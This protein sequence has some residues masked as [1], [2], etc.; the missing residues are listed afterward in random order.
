MNKLTSWQKS[1]IILVLMAL[2]PVASAA[3]TL[4]TLA[5]FNGIDGSD[6]Y[7][8]PLLQ[9]TDGNFYGTTAYGGANCFSTGC[10]TVFKITP[11]GVL[12]TLYSFCA[13]SSCSDGDY[14][15]AGL[16]QAADGNFYGTTSQGGSNG[17]AGSIFKITSAGK[18]TTLYSFC[19][20]TNCADGN[21]VTG[22]LI[23]GAD[24]NFYG[25]TFSGGIGDAQ[26]CSGGCGTVFKLTP[27]GIL[28]TLHNFSGYN[29]EGSAPNAGLVQ[30]KNGNFYGTT[31]SGGAFNTCSVGCN[32]TVFEITP[33]GS[34]TTLH[35]FAA[36]PTDGATP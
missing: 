19:S 28:T 30:A 31:T 1:L 8:A 5:S 14:P 36:S 17:H 22:G 4:T 9:G 26:Y 35:S 21:Y 3:Q 12:T 20:Q 18:L 34:L 29:I 6:P 25:T 11:K 24:G 16:I 23:Q 27:Q 13:Q 33:A 32:G 15:Y 10:G 7:S 2:M